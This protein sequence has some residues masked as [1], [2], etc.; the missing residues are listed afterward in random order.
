MNK[1]TRPIY[2][3]VSN[4]VTSAKIATTFFSETRYINNFNIRNVP[5][6]IIIIIINFYG[7]YILRNLSCEAQQNIII[8]IIVN[9]GKSQYQNE[10]QPN[11]YGGNAIW[12]RYVLSFFGK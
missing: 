6:I 5:K 12:N 8:N 7:A 11:M 1:N 9:K 4:L 10:G 2:M 3:W